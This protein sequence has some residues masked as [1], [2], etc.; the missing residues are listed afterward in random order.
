MF[1]G[2]AWWAAQAREHGPGGRCLSTRLGQQ[3]EDRASLGLPAADKASRF[4]RRDPCC[5]LAGRLGG[6]QQQEKS[7]SGEPPGGSKAADYQVMK[8]KGIGLPR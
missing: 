5:P 6:S 8:N 7:Q 1:R 4:P 2:K 3:S